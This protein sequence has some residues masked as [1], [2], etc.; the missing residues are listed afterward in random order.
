MTNNQIENYTDKIRLITTYSIALGIIILLI[1]AGALVY[2][3]WLKDKIKRVDQENNN[4][5]VDKNPEIP[6]YLEEPNNRLKSLYIILA[7]ALGFYILGQV[8][9]SIFI[10][11]Y[12]RANGIT[13]MDQL[14][15][16]SP[17]YINALC[18]S[19]FITYV[20]TL[21]LIII[22]SVK[23]LAVDI[24]NF[25]NHPSFY[26]KWTGLG[27]VIMWVLIIVSNTLVTIFS[28]GISST[29]ESENQKIITM[30]LTSGPGN[31]LLMGSVTVLLAPFIEELV[32][33]KGLFGIF[34]TKTLLTVVISSVIFAGIHVVPA[35]V[36]DI[37]AINTGDATVVDLYLEAIS[38]IS[39]LGQ[40]FA[41]SYTY[42]KTKGN[43]IP[44]MIIHLA[45][46]LISLIATL[47]I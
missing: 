23:V 39:Y 13:D 9:S 32:F 38:I 27:F 4:E 30:I 12:L 46:N 7:Y 43:I 35:C 37:I 42:Y 1:I 34:K 40:A 47:F 17:I 6:N 28:N 21:I 36:S 29:V 11:F 41:L 22:V 18:Y 25:S 3:F 5:P 24:R 45:N 14:T 2:H 10:S 8:I 15:S 16:D 44:C 33:R 19:N 31:L 26:L 20:V